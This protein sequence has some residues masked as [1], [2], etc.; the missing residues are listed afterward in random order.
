LSYSKT[1]KIKLSKYDKIWSQFVRERDGQCQ[2]CGKRD[3]LAA[4][5]IKGRSC[6]STRLLL[7]NGISLCPS[8]HTFN[9]QFSAHR[10][11]EAFERWFKKEYPNRYKE[12]RKR[13]QT[14]MPEREAIAEF[15]EMYNLS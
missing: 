5:H 3:Y 14:M 8:C 1:R 9:H 2:V 13:A 11:P 15:I 10:T 7:D 6:K 12:I 4:H